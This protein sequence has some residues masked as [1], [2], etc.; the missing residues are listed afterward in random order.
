[1][2]TVCLVSCVGKKLNGWSSAENL[3]QSDWFQKARVYAQSRSDRWFIL[4]AYHGVIA[5]TDFIDPYNKT[6]NTMKAA[7]R[8]AWANKV[9]YQLSNI[10]ADHFIIL[11]GNRYRERITKWMDDTGYSYDVPM[12]GLGIGQ[13]LAWLKAA[14]KILTGETQ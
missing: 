13:Q 6:L 2:R 7:E 9:I 10:D 14:N 12:E 5:P 8:K 3:Y 1:M 11:A 4:S